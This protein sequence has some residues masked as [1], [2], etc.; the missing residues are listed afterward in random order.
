MSQGPLMPKATAVWLVE[1]TSL[2]FEQIAEFCKL[3]PLEVKGIADGEVA[4]GI[5]G[6]D[7]ITTGQLTRDEIERAQRVPNYKLKVA[8]SKVK[9]PEVKRTT[10]GPRYT[11]LS[12]RQ[13][14]PNA[15]LW[16]LRNHPELKDAQIIRLV[17]TTK[18]TIQQIRERTHWNSAS[19]QPMDPVTLGLCTQI[20]LDFEVQRSAKDR[21]ANLPADGGATLLPTEIST[22]TDY[23]ETDDHHR[24][25]RDEKLNADSVFAKL[26]G[27][28]NTDDEDDED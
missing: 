18:S 8:V 15:I 22:A 9:L 2:A 10:K 5:K 6:L 23:T 7:P 27:M 14:R 16:L 4:A 25:V 21:P 3:H 19:L 28:R 26:K 24:S 13:D 17:G 11:P 12:R 20:D 1:N